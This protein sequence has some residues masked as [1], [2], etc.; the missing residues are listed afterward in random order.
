MTITS[1]LTCMNPKM[2]KRDERNNILSKPY[3][4]D[5]YATDIFRRRFCG[6]QTHFT[7]EMKK[8]F[9]GKVLNL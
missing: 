2:D 8:K 4:F 5:I 6:I 7:V 9:N 1:F 3:L